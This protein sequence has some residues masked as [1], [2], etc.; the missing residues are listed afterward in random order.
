M[1]HCFGLGLLHFELKD[2]IHFARPED[3]RTS[4]EGSISLKQDKQV[5][6]KAPQN[7]IISRD[8]MFDHVIRSW[9]HS[10][11]YTG[12]HQGFQNEIK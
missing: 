6:N 5:Q 10:S 9:V 1:E 3:Q 4:W 7:C 11:L 12:A 8:T 2:V